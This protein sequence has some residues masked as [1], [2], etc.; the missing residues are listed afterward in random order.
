MLHRE[1]VAIPLTR[2]E[3]WELAQDA[4][5]DVSR[6]VT[7]KLDLPVYL[8]RAAGT[9]KLRKAHE[10]GTTVV[11]QATFLALAGVEPAPEEVVRAVLSEIELR[12]T[13]RADAAARKHAAATETARRRSRKP[14]AARRAGAT[15]EEL[16]WCAPGQHEWLRRY[17][18]PP[19]PRLP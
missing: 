14:V 15:V 11:D 6:G 12:R 3:V 7:K 13:A 1:F 16:L 9:S 19:T 10:Y 17:T 18:W 4:G 5:M 8:D 2:E